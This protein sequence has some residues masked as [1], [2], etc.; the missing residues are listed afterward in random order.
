M[1]AKLL[2]LREILTAAQDMGLTG[3]IVGPKVVIST[4]LGAVTVRTWDDLY[5][6]L[7]VAEVAA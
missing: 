1:Y 5:T 4:A 7:E 2:V 3:V 6:A